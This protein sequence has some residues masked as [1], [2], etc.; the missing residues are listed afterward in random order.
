MYHNYL[1]AQ[2]RQIFDNFEEVFIHS[3][4]TYIIVPSLSINE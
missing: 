4:L 2:I 1:G 3:V